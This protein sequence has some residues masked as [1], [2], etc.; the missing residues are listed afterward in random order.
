MDRSADMAASWT[1]C[2]DRAISPGC[3]YRRAGRQSLGLLHGTRLQ[4]MIL[5]QIMCPPR[6]PP[7]SSWREGN[8]ADAL[9]QRR[10][11]S[12][13]LP[14]GQFFDGDECL[15][16]ASGHGAR[17]LG[18]EVKLTNDDRMTSRM[19]AF[20]ASALASS[21]ESS[22]GFT[23]RRTQVSPPRAKAGPALTKTTG[24]D[25]HLRVVNWS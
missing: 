21:S 7:H 19:S 17:A 22:R 4:Q 8:S 20:S 24:S 12:P 15:Q 14:L 18:F 13:Q 10:T 9:S 23:S 1:P 3:I 16:K 5:D 11:S 6:P 25:Q 2:P